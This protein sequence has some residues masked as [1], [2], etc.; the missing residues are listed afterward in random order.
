MKYERKLQKKGQ[1]YEE[2]KEDLQIDNCKNIR[3]SDRNNKGIIAGGKKKS[4]YKIRD[5]AK[6]FDLVIILFK[7][8]VVFFFLFYIFMMH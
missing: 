5:V 4:I 6:N 3:I 2:M 7:V 8:F 1:L